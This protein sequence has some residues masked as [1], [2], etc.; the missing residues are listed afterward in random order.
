MQEKLGSSLGRIIGWGLIS[1]TLLVTPLWSLDPINPIKMLAV[2]ATGFMCIGLVVAN[3]KSVSWGKYRTVGGLI[4]AFVVWQVLVV[5]VS[6][7]EINQQLFGS[8]GRN[9]GL[10]TY[11]AFSLIFLGSVIASNEEAIKRLVIVQ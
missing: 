4:V 2:V 11:L 9:T 5:L 1:A 8:Q 7:G 10:V 6:D 3:R